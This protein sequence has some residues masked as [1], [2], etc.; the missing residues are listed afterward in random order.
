MYNDVYNEASNILKYKKDY[1]EYTK[2]GNTELANAAAQRAKK[3]YDYLNESGYADV[4]NYFKNNGY[5]NSKNYF[6]SYFSVQPGQYDQ[7]TISN[8]ITNLKNLWHSADESGDKETAE[9]YAAKAQG[10]YSQMN[11]NGDE[12]M[13]SNLQNRNASQ[14]AEYV[15]NYYNTLGKTAMRPY[16]Y[17]KG[18]DYGLSQADVDKAIS[19]NSDTGE[20]SLGGK[21][22]GKADAYTDGTSYWNSDTLD[23]AWNDYVK[24]AGLTKT[25]DTMSKQMWQRYNDDYITLRDKIANENPY[26]NDVGKS[27]LAKYDLSAFNSGNNAA[28]SGA[29]SNGGNIDSFSAA[30]A[31]RNQ[32]EM[33]A[34]GQQA[35]LDAHNS[36]VDKLSGILSEYGKNADVV[37]NESETSKLNDDTLKNNEVARDVSIM[38]TT[39]K[40][41]DKYTYGNNPFLNNDGS[42]KDENINYKE[43]MDNA[44]ERLKTESN[45]EE[46]KRLNSLIN[47]ASQARSIKLDKKYN[48]DGRY[49]QWNDGDYVFNDQDTLERYKV[50]KEQ[51][52]LK[53]TVDGSIK[54]TQISEDAATART[55]STND[56][57]ERITEKTLASNE[58]M[59]S[60]NNQTKK[61]MNSE[62]NETNKQIYSSDTKSNNTTTTSDNTI[63]EKNVEAAVTKINTY[64]PNAVTTDAS[65]A[66]V[67]KN[68]YKQR[69][70]E[71]IKN[72]GWT[73]EQC[74]QIAAK[75]GITINEISG[76]GG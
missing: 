71:Q 53:Y 59:N 69:A 58:R 37:F 56:A 32:T 34:Q 43:I 74:L 11:A 14:A 54:Q 28:A 68:E 52:G 75:L 35:A 76:Y 60:E 50:D 24:N 72:Q 48:Y 65:G 44:R 41:L 38:S 2:Q 21:N 17:T 61:E 3:S 33:I 26:T 8:K 66:Y 67:V 47:Y 46:V 40:V 64:Y 10:Y 29:A 63:T 19:Y 25:S 4:A 51:E 45:A 20:I 9:G 13:A 70:W 6:D 22:L 42:L 55:N 18:A 30:N 1:D 15:K 49:S 57:N 62:N 36:R 7:K 31:M 39:G 73:Y 12:I 27:I 5:S 16:L 23:A